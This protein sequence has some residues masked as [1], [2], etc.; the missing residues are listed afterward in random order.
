MALIFHLS[1]RPPCLKIYLAF[2]NG[3]RSTTRHLLERILFLGL[4]FL[5]VKI[6]EHVDPSIFNLCQLLLALDQVQA[7][8][9]QGLSPSATLYQVLPSTA[10]DVLQV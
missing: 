9:V 4:L 5:V 6:L 7:V 1:L 8:P 2:W 3:R 10:D